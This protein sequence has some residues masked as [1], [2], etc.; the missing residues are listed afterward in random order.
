MG[1]IN[2][3]VRGTSSLDPFMKIAEPFIGQ[4]TDKQDLSGIVIKSFEDLTKSVV[5]KKENWLTKFIEVIKAVFAKKQVKPFDVEKNLTFLYDILEQC[6]VPQD[7][8]FDREVTVLK[9]LDTFIIRLHQ[10]IDPNLPS[11]L[12]PLVEKIDKKINEFRTTLS[13]DIKK[14]S[15]ETK[16]RQEFE[17]NAALAAKAFSLTGKE[18][19]DAIQKLGNYSS[20]NG[21]RLDFIKSFIGALRQYR[22]ITNLE[23][24]LEKML[25]IDTDNLCYEDAKDLY[26]E[27]QRL[28]S[29]LQQLLQNAEE[30]LE[31][32]STHRQFPNE[33]DSLKKSYMSLIDT[34]S[35]KLSRSEQLEKIA[36]LRL[37]EEKDIEHLDKVQESIQGSTSFI[38]LNIWVQQ[39]RNE[40]ATIE[41]KNFPQATKDLLQEKVQECVDT[42]ITT[43]LDVSSKTRSA[44]T[45]IIHKYKKVEMPYNELLS[46]NMAIQ[47]FSY[48]L[49]QIEAWLQTDIDDKLKT[50]LRNE[51]TSAKLMLKD[52]ETVL[53]GHFAK[54]KQKAKED[55]A[56][57]AGHAAPHHQQTGPVSGQ[58]GG[59]TSGTLEVHPGG[60]ITIN[61]YYGANKEFT[62]QLSSTVKAALGQGLLSFADIGSL[63]R[64]GQTAT[65]GLFTALKIGTTV[66]PFGIKVLP[67]VAMLGYMFWSGSA[68]STLIFTGVGMGAGLGIPY[69]VPR[70]VPA[71]FQRYLPHITTG[72]QMLYYT[73]L[74]WLVRMADRQFTNLTPA[75]SQTGAATHDQASTPHTPPAQP[76]AEAAAQPQQSPPQAKPA[77]V[78]KDVPQPAPKQPAPAAAQS[79]QST[80]QANLAPAAEEP[81]IAVRALRVANVVLHYLGASSKPQENQ[82][83]GQ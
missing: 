39:M 28:K 81:S 31:K 77:H 3:P 50:K 62:D 61:N 52:A 65:P 55:I 17:S 23:E 69:I 44:I 46:L 42:L 22:A 47:E 71:R 68:I 72:T 75:L 64:F 48:A 25:K 78:T 54:L 20:E 18:L 56:H 1:E 2:D 49:P 12:Q 51:I 38:E 14:K 24:P 82:P 60:S 41:K 7:M 33:V 19:D 63:V 36:R 66:L 80:P 10:V 59:V 40:I 30:K 35:S 27:S 45:D 37:Y 53:E 26:V 16:L 8:P 73:S 32:A 79:Q 15:P 58:T 67:S 57:T 29:K 9:S 43:T 11:A 74:P 5:Y 13:D 76:K 70:V 21:A 4:T 83:V 6:A 34:A